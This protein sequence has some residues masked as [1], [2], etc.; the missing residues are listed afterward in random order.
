MRNQIQQEFIVMIIRIASIAIKHVT[1]VMAQ[2]VINA[3]VVQTYSFIKILVWT[4]AQINFMPY[5]QHGNV[6][7]IALW[8]HTLCR[9]RSSVSTNVQKRHFSIT[10]NVIIHNKPYPIVIKQR[11]LIFVMIVTQL[12]RNALI[13]YLHHA[14]NVNLASTCMKEHVNHHALNLRTNMSKRNTSGT[15]NK[16]NLKKTVIIVQKLVQVGF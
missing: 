11:K 15:M 16:M 14:P 3:K 4:S 13:G 5:Q 6:N 12:A 9:V 10:D 1:L 2:I 7:L 8:G